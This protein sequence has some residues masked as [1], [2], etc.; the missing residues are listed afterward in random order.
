MTEPKG[1]N[2]SSPINDEYRL[3]IDSSCMWIELKRTSEKGKERVERVSGYHF[4]FADLIRSL[5]KRKSLKF[6]AVE[7]LRKLAETQQH[8]HDEIRDLCKDLKDVP[9]L[10]RDVK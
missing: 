4:T 7:T 1:K 8:M 10:V 6:D 9:E 3:V 2:R 5:E